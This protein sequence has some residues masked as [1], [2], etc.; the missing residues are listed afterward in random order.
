M[1]PTVDR[2]YGST[3]MLVR[4]ESYKCGDILGLWLGHKVT[5]KVLRTSRVSDRVGGLGS[6]GSIHNNKNSIK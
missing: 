2:K 6:F 1:F 3:Q 5:V 4:P